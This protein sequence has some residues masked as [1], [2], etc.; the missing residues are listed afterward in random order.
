MGPSPTSMTTTLFKMPTWG[1]ARPT[2][3][4]S[5]MV[6]IISSI[7]WDRRGV[8]SLISLLVL[9]RISSPSTRMVRKLIFFS[10]CF[11]SVFSLFFSIL[12]NA[13]VYRKRFLLFS[14]PRHSG[15]LY[16]LGPVLSL[17]PGHPFHAPADPHPVI[18]YWTSTSTRSCCQGARLSRPFLMVTRTWRSTCLIYNIL[19]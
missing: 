9:R 8:I 12:L 3:S 13:P 14:V 5:Y 18:S 19:R 2:P 10:S 17:E 11:L 16:P 1:A 15:T 4:L 6:S 7:S